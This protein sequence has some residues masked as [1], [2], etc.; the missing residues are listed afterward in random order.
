MKDMKK[1]TAAI[2]LLVL[3]FI[4]SLINLNFLENWLGGL[5]GQALEAA[6][7]VDNGNLE[8]ASAI[9]NTSLDDWLSKDNYVHIMLRHDEI[10]PI[11]DEYFALLDELNSGGDAT[12]AS[13]GTLLSHLHELQ[14]M[15]RIS[16]SS[17]F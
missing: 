15:E 4:V 14:D 11:T 9:L 10:D 3:I 7:Y 5:S 17:I 12:S 1:E 13:F 16:L 8:K 6:E 2:V